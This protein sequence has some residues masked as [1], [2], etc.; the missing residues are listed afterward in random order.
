VAVYSDRSVD[1][2][3]VCPDD[4]FRAKWRSTEVCIMTVHLDPLRVNFVC[5]VHRSQFSVTRGNIV[6]NV[7]ATSSEGTGDSCPCRPAGV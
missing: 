3:S 6:A 5:Q 2:V 1:R 4:R 7:G